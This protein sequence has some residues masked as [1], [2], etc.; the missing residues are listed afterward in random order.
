MSNVDKMALTADRNNTNSCTCYSCGK[1]GNTAKYFFN[2]NKMRTHQARLA[3]TESE[4][5]EESIAFVAVEI[6]NTKEEKAFVAGLQKQ[7]ILDSGANNHM[8]TNKEDFE[9]IEESD[10]SVKIG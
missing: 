8:F 9:K 10:V 1:V 4:N 7:T 2:Q 6:C 5:E 3:Q